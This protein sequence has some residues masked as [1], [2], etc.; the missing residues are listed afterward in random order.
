MVDKVLV[1]DDEETLRNNV[2]RYLETLGYGIES[3][4]NGD[5]AAM[6]LEKDAFD[7]L[8]TDIRMEGMDGLEL[9]QHAHV[10][11]P[12][13]VALVMTGYAGLDSALE[14]FRSG[15]FDYVKKPFTLEELGRKV[16]HISRFRSLVR[17]NTSLRYELKKRHNASAIVAR[18]EAVRRVNELIQKV[19]K[20]SSNILITGESGTGKELIARAVH[21]NSRVK[22]ALFIPVNIAAIP[23]NLV[24]SFLFGH[25][26]GAFTGAGSNRE[27]V[28]RAASNG[29]LLL[30][31]IGEMSLPVQ[32]KMLRALEE[33]EIMPIGSDVPVKVTTRV[34]AATHRDLEAMVQ[35]GTFR[36]DLLLR[37][38]VVTIHIS[39]LRERVED[40]PLL[41]R[42]FIEKHCN[43]QGRVVLGIDKQAMRC[44]ISYDWEKSNVRELSNAIERAVIL[45]DADVISMTDLSPEVRETQP[46]D[47]LSLSDAIKQF[48]YRYILSV[49]EGVGGNREVA[50]QTLGIS[51][52]TL[53]RRMQSI[54]LSG[55]RNAV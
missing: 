38:N 2:A 48:E 7:I 24:E 35:A 39:P 54:G 37:L 30:D 42:H 5:E 4:S 49:L 23:E 6:L 41:V 44:L 22:D 31:E 20:V 12:E 52:S 17:E 45:C 14:A 40:I 32:A 3:A 29:T 10:V 13:T 9:L 25:R 51:P 11:A 26:R 8:V 55:Y 36:Q 19:A 33:K 28:F 34:I 21:D 47:A 50:A 16:E 53:Y 18:S 1:V 43:E 27:G 15:A 46:E